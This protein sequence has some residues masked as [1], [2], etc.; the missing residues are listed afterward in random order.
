MV[1]MDAEPL[2]C[3]MTCCGLGIGGKACDCPKIGGPMPQN[4]AC[5]TSCTDP[6]MWQIAPDPN[7]GCLFAT[8][9]PAAQ[10]CVPDAGVAD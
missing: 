4:C 7:S 2:D 1:L 6:G 3:G 8:V 10:I 5:P 9:D